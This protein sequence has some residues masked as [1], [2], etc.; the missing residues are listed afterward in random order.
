MEPKKVADLLL[1]PGKFVVDI[2][3]QA[4]VEVKLGGVPVGGRSL[5]P[6]F[7]AFACR[8]EGGVTE[9]D[10]IAVGGVLLSSGLRGERSDENDNHE[11]SLDYLVEHR[12]GSF[13]DW[14]R[15]W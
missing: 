6:G 10:T 12:G 3:G 5:G 4:E 11:S 15:Y 14:F 9:R 8:L 13:W 1:L 7:L 2:V